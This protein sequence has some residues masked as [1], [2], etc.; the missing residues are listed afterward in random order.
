MKVLAIETSSARGGV[1]LVSG[2]NV[3]A[4]VELPDKRHHAQVLY[5]AVDECLREGTL[6]LRSLDGIAVSAGPGSF[7][8]LRVGMACAKGL[9][10]AV[11]LPVAL[12]RTL[13]ALLRDVSATRR[14]RIACVTRAFQERL[15]VLVGRAGETVEEEGPDEVIQPEK[16]LCK[17][18]PGTVLF[19]DGA[20]AYAETFSGFEVHPEPS[21]PRA[22]T[23]ALVGEEMLARGEGVSAEKALPRYLLTSEA[24]RKLED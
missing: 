19:G 3:L 8:G 5:S 18:E 2:G 1:A 10:W 9:A 4:Q 23:V 16:L 14:G 20:A 11:G 21:A 22:S 24:E 12:V 13:S 17:L 15:Y 6:D 7:T